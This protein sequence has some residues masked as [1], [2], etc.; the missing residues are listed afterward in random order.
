MNI[1][2]LTDLLKKLQETEKKLQETEKKP[3]NIID[4]LIKITQ[5]A[6]C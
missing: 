6:T 3:T 5:Y 4:I 2:E 1:R